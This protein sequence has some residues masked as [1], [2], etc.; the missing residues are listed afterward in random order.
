MEIEEICSENI[1]IYSKFMWFE[2]SRKNIS[3]VTSTTNSKIPT[4][5]E[6]Q[7]GDAI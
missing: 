1:R 6:V 2:G 5:K 7:F 4:K 3:N